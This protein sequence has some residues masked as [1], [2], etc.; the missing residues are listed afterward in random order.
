MKVNSIFLGEQEVD[1]DTVITFPK[2]IPGFEGET[3]YKLFN[4]EGKPSVYWLQSLADPA[5]TFSVAL[6]ET[7]GFAYEMSLS[8]EEVTLLG[9]DDP[10]RITVMLLLSRPNDEKS[11]DD[12]ALTENGIRANLNGPLLLNVDKRLAMQKVL[13]KTEQITL[14]RSIDE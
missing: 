8:D 12:A 1:P 11:A 13:P 14:I 3:Q 10:A 6:P 4:E 5:V 2:G 9:A 7:F